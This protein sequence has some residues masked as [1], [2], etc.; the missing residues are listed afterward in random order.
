M[1]TDQRRIIEDM[2]AAFTNNNPGQV[3]QFEDLARREKANTQLWIPL[4][5][6]ILQALAQEAAQKPDA[7]KQM[8]TLNAAIEGARE[9]MTSVVR[10]LKDLDTSAMDSALAG[11]AATY[12]FWKGMAPFPTIL[13]EDMQLQTNAISRLA[14]KNSSLPPP[15]RPEQE[16]AL[17]L[18]HLFSERLAAQVPEGGDTPRNLVPGQTPDP[19]A[20]TN[21]AAAQPGAISAETRKQ[22]LLLADNAALAQQSALDALKNSKIEEAIA[23]QNRGYNILKEIEKLLPKDKQNQPQQKP[24]QQPDPPPDQPPP[25]PQEKKEDK[26]KEEQPPEDVRKMMEK[27]LQREKDH[28]QE[29]QRQRAIH[30]MSPHEKDW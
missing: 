25:Q 11:E 18:T 6:K 13:Q 1:L 22:I 27:A 21:A 30:P 15:L 10:S 24:E 23:E 26:P 3:Y 29:K 9:R 5:G 4:K 20:D 28:E 2:A 12:Q 19:T 7:Q 17:A 16:E 14:S 8:A